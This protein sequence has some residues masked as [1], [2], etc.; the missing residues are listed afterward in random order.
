[1]VRVQYR[2][3]L[4]TQPNTTLSGEK[5][6]SILNTIHDNEPTD[7]LGPGSGEVSNYLLLPLEQGLFSWT[8]KTFLK[9]RI[10]KDN[11]G[12]LRL[13]AFMGSVQVK[14]LHLKYLDQQL[15]PYLG[16]PTAYPI[17]MIVCRALTMKEHVSVPGSW[18]VL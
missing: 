12:Q 5:Y 6:Q 16:Y 2:Y 1:M 4:Y 8:T 18:S 17:R 15:L 9:E 3:Y 13:L 7:I 11:P 10:Y 14:A